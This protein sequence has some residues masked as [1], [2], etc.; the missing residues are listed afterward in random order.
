MTRISGLTVEIVAWRP[1][2]L[3]A[4]AHGPVKDSPIRLAPR[5]RS[6]RGARRPDARLEPAGGRPRSPG[7]P[8]R[9]LRARP[10]RGLE[11]QLVR[12]ALHTHLQRSLPAP[13]GAARAADGGDP[14][15]RLL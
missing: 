1:T 2:I 4:V 9:A 10:P 11:R 15:R 8:H 13:G 14:R 5:G 3:G 12:R 7:L 6:Q